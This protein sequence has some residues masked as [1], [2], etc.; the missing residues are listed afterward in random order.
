MG[1]NIILDAVEQITSMEYGKVIMHEEIAELIACSYPSKKYR[2]VLAKLKSL[3]LEKSKN[4]ESVKGLGYRITEPD[5][6]EFV[7]RGYLKKAAR[8]SDKSNKVMNYAPV[9]KMSMLARQRHRD[10][11]DH[12]AR[13]RAHMRAGVV[14][15]NLLSKRVKE[16]EYSGSENK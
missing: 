4:L 14:E 1:N 9:D 2:A 7:A 8:S 5:N 10:I 13:L 16:L 6:Y 11:S 3:C 12:I 15:V